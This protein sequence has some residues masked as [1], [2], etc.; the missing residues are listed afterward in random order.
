[1]AV[2]PVSFAMSMRPGGY[3]QAKKNLLGLSGDIPGRFLREK[4]VGYA[5]IPLNYFSLVFFQ[6]SLICVLVAMTGFCGFSLVRKASFLTLV[7]I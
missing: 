2:W 7:L 4:A 6:E 1:M 3:R 5:T